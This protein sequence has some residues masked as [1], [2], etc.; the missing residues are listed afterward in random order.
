MEKME[1]IVIIYPSLK[2]TRERLDFGIGK[3]RN[4]RAE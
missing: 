4:Q 1:A 2:K 3:G